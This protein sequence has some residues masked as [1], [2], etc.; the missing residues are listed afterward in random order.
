MPSLV[1]N[2]KPGYS[3]AQD[4]DHKV[5]DYYSQPVPSVLSLNT[6]P[7]PELPPPPAVAYRALAPIRMVRISRIEM[8]AGLPDKV[9]DIPD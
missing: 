2:R 7:L 9:T 5:S 6:V 1:R 3:A 8:V 4:G